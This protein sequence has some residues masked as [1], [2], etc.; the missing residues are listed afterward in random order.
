LTDLV[1]SGLVARFFDAYA[2]VMIHCR[3]RIRAALLLMFAGIAISAFPAA[4]P[5]TVTFGKWIT[6]Q[7][8]PNT[9]ATGESRP[10]INLPEFDTFYSPTNWY[11]DY[12]AYWGGSDDG[13]RV[14][15]VVTQISRPEKHISTARNR[16][17]SL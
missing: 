8:L 9:A 3:W 4:K 13:Q 7:W 10:S 14:Y 5:H 17:M 15:A 2:R 11:R 6:V 16:L 12:A 1:I